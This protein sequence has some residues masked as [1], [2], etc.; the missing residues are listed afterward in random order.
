MTRRSIA[1]AVNIIEGGFALSVG[2]ADMPA[3]PGWT[4]HKLTDI[5]RLESGHTPSR[6]QE[7][8]WNGP[9]PWISIP[10]ARRHHGGWI[11]ETAQMVTQEGIDNSAARLLP[12]GTVCLSRTASVGY[13]T[14]MG[15]PMAT[16][17]DFVNWVCS[18]AI[19]PDYLRCLLLAEKDALLRFGK[20]STHTT[21]YFPEVQAFRVCAPPVDEQRRIVAKLDALRARSRRAKEALDAVP[22]LL[23]KLRQSI[24][25]AAF[26]GDLTAD[27]R[28]ANPD[29]EPASELLKRIRVERETLAAAGTKRSRDLVPSPGAGDHDETWFG[30]PEDRGWALQTLDGLSDPIRGIPY[31]IVQTGESD[32]RGIP[33]VRCGDIKGFQVVLEAL[34]RVSPS[35]EAEYK[36][37]RLVGG[38]VL[39][40]IRGTV[41]QTAVA[42]EDLRGANVTV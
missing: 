13:V 41:G 20:G 16:S 18:E 3:P 42:G 23:D 25:A 29:V 33:T 14:V 39:I 34:K 2:D 12:K 38:E 5:A 19:D 11:T 35:I 21:I 15:R 36:R 32:P 17:Q 10:D 31:G 6:S 8:Y 22:A 4:W 37:T 27:W 9:I 30:T 7:S 24:L 26:R 28:E 1:D 40:A